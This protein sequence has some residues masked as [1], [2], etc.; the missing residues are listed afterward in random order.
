MKEAT[1]S[2]FPGSTFSPRQ[3]PGKRRMTKSC[4]RAD[5]K[6]GA[7]KEKKREKVSVPV[8][9]PDGKDEGQQLRVQEVGWE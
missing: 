1:R 9:H 3:D 6:E 7:A 5:G 4:L 8:L 2:P